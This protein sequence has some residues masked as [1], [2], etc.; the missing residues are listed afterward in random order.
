M[1]SDIVPAAS[2]V[3]TRA[4]PKWE[5]VAGVPGLWSIERLDRH[6]WSLRS[7][8]LVLRDGST[9]VVSPMRRLGDPAHDTLRSLGRTAFALAPN[10]YHWLGLSEFVERH[11]RA[12]VVA[13]DTARVRLAKKSP[14]AMRSLDALREVLP[15]GVEIVEPRSLRN[16]ETWLSIPCEGGRAWVV[17]DAFFN[18]PVAPRGFV[19]W[20]L[21]AMQITPGLK[22]GKTFRWVGV[23]DRR[24]YV[25]WLEERL[26]RDRPVVLVPGH[27]EVLTSPDAA[28]M[29]NAATRKGLKIHR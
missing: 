3:P 16:G 29:L 14:L 24:D 11:D 27:G 12:V 4:A 9:L 26:E 28:A 23:R 10:H 17:S 22:V 20:M 13:S 7:T 18:V 8:A 15:D 25:A 2:T 6:G 19:G 21:R 5:P 1:K